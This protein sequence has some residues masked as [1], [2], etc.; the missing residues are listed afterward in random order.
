MCAHALGG[1]PHTSQQHVILLWEAATDKM[2]SQKSKKIK[3]NRRLEVKR[4]GGQKL[5]NGDPT[6]KK[7]HLV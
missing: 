3:K 7:Q 6:P 2:L 4:A 1:N 5:S